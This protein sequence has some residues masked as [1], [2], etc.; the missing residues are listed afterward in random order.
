M[1]TI[2]IGDVVEVRFE[3]LPWLIDYT[4]T[5]LPEGI[6]DTWFLIG[7]EGQLVYLANYAYMVLKQKKTS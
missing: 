2:G 1:N 5:A 6:G 4:V 7:P 3:N